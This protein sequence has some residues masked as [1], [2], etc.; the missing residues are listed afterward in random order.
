MRLLRVA[1]FAAACAALFPGAR[2][3]YGDGIIIAPNSFR[4]QRERSLITEPDQ[5]AVIVYSG[6]T[7]RL[8]ISPS[9]RGDARE[10]AWV[11]PVP[12]RPQV[13][14][15]DGA[16]FHDLAR[17]VM[18]RPPAGFGAR[19]KTMSAPMAGVAVLERKPVGAYDV[20]V[21]A[22]SDGHALMK[23]LAGNGYRLP[24]RAEAPVRAYVREGWT[25]VACRVRVPDSARGL[26]SG[27]LAPLS[28]TFRAYQPVYPMRLS[29]ANSGDFDLLVYVASANRETELRLAQ[30]PARRRDLRARFAATY[31]PQQR[32]EYP[33]LARVVRNTT[34]IHM[35]HGRMSPEE[36]TQD[37]VWNPPVESRAASLSRRI[38]R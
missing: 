4:E 26:K 38:P 18:P 12:R 19:A 2:R 31:E 11:V 35:L 37:F 9:Y 21:L 23:W 16:L 36:C 14:K 20:S 28:L 10:F 6:R 17:L 29:S 3:A 13:D 33:T 15:V 30:A 1:L 8:I 27:T 34:R 22:A 5:K 7:E 32:W 25:F 24:A